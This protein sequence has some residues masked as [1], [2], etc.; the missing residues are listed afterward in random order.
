MYSINL[1]TKI[2]VNHYSK[3]LEKSKNPILLKWLCH[4]IRHTY[5][6][7]DVAQKIINTDKN[8]YLLGSEIKRN[9]E[10]WC[11]LHDIWRF[12]QHDG[13]NLIST[14]K[15]DHGD[16]WFEILVDEWVDIKSVLLSVKYH[17]KLD[18]NDMYSDNLYIDSDKKEKTEIDIV[19]KLVRDADKLQ[20]LEYLL[21]DYNNTLENFN[22]KIYK[23]DKV[24]PDNY[25]SN[26]NIEYLE[27]NK[28]I[29]HKNIKSIAERYCW[30]LSWLFDINFE[31]TKDI[32]IFDDIKWFFV[33]K[34]SSLWVDSKIISIIKNITIKDQQC[35][36]NHR[37]SYFLQFRW[38]SMKII[39]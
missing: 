12:Y 6:V 33:Q 24:V 29:L 5:G 20:N 23:S 9:M 2:L 3:Q 18:I 28:M 38:K 13:N 11:L 17:N 26:V 34:L 1:A 25:I 27:N 30:T 14:S 7:L 16:K 10:L 8:L 37:C 19:T 36:L 21:F 22:K 4:K 35:L 32:I 15:F 31:W 39:V